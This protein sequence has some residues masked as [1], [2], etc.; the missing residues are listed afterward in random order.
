MADAPSEWSRFFAELKRRR[1]FRVAAAYLAAAFVVLQ[2]ADYLFRGLALPD[3]AFRLIVVVAVL[4]FVIAVP[5][6]WVY[7]VGP[8]GIRRTLPLERTPTAEPQR[9]S[10]VRWWPAVATLAVLVIAVGSWLALRGR[11]PATNPHRVVV[12]AFENQTGDA[13]LAPLGNMAADWITQGLIETGIVEVVDAPTALAIAGEARHDSVAGPDAVRLFSRET[14]AGLVVTGRYYRQADSLEFIA[15]VVDAGT[16]KMVRVVGPVTA[17]TALPVQ[18]AERLRARLMTELAVLL[19]ERLARFQALER[20]PPSYDAYREYMEGLAGYLSM[21]G[22]ALDHFDRAFVLDSTFYR[23]ALWAA[24]C[25]LVA[26]PV[27]GLERYDSLLARVERRRARLTPVEQYQLDFVRALRAGDIR[28]AYAAARLRWQAEPGSDDALRELV[29]MAFHVY[30][31]REANELYARI[32]WNR[33]LLRRLSTSLGYVALVQH[34]RGDFEGEL[35]TAAEWARRAPDWYEPDARRLQALAALGRS[36]EVRSLASGLADR[37]AD[38]PRIGGLGMG[39]TNTLNS[40]VAPFELAAR[41]LNEHGKPLEARA[42][43]R[44]G[45]SRCAGPAPTPAQLRSESRLSCASLLGFLGRWRDAD[46]LL[47]GMNPS[48][49]LLPAYLT[50]AG[51]AAAQ[52]GDR[53]RAHAFSDSLA[54][55][56]VRTV[57][58]MYAHPSV[59]YERAMIAAALGDREDALRRLRLWRANGDWSTAT[60]PLSEPIFIPYFTDPRFRKLLESED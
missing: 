41:E 24:E 34:L 33:G 14:G 45:V 23:A 60:T 46:A 50:Y 37:L 9:P 35:R 56:P 53:A 51:M 10:R 54:R 59:E 32:D 47:R 20:Q 31:F 2:F 11:Q 27:A 5:L 8:G 58:D 22:T 25:V 43:A 40:E 4:G 15:Q 28:A 12:A 19:D 3:W 55:R 6:A 42:L 44:D 36:E 13:T 48:E 57:G 1:V 17:P 26:P 16:G 49:L 52:L 7:D 21:D 30:H 38:D 29:F 18:G 39:A